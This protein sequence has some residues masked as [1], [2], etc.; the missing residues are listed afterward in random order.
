MPFSSL[1]VLSHLVSEKFEKPDPDPGKKKLIRIRNPAYDQNKHPLNF[2][3]K[4]KIYI[5]I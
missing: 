2:Q 4:R 1:T 3:K 5:D